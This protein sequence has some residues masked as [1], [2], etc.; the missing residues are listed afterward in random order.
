VSPNSL[1]GDVAYDF[2]IVGAGS[3]GCVLANRLSRDP[4]TQ[5]LLLEAGPPDRKA[6]VKVPAAWTKLLGSDLDWSYVTQPQP[7]L[8]NRRVPWPRGKTLGG[9]SSINAQIYLRGHR[10]D[11]DEWAAEGNDGWGYEAVRPYFERA[12]NRGGA[13]S[14]A[15]RSQGP[16]HIAEVPDPHPLSVAWVDAVI[17]AGI[18]ANDG[19]EMDGVGLVELTQ[20]R[21]VRCSTVDAYLRPALGRTNLTVAV[22]AHATRVLFE[23]RRAVAVEYRRDGRRETAR[24]GGEVILSGGVVNSPQ[25][26][27]L[28]GVGP[29]GHLRTQGIDVV[30]DLPGVGRNLQ[31]HFAVTVAFAAGASGPPP[32]LES[33]ANLLRFVVS[34]RGKLTSSGPEACAFVHTTDDMAAPD[35][36][37]L[38]APPRL[39]PLVPTPRW[40]ATRVR[41]GCR[42]L[43]HARTV[44]PTRPRAAAVTAAVVRPASVGFLEL[45]SADPLAPPVIDPRYLEDSGGRDLRVLV[46]GVKL[47]RRL[48]TFPALR[49]H[50]TEEL[51]PGAHVERDDDIEEFVRE[52]AS[53]LQHPIGTCR[54]GSDAMA[55]VD[56]E[57]RVRGMSGLR[58]V[59]ASIM[60][61]IPR[62]HMN[63]PSIM[64]AEKA[65]DLILGGVTRHRSVALEEGRS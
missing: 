60:P 51:I 59:D 41:D 31:D 52:D 42:H 58:V 32:A 9:S 53:T 54:M 11:F 34:R 4:R 50:V 18:P 30:H 63:A 62:G 6:A 17:E 27:L 56:S 29:A 24:A 46:E 64:I 55:V 35:L 10:T 8:H 65:A 36:E 39:R 3:A 44:R 22:G 2:V 57:L 28:S 47:A 37:L 15:S 48:M 38:F 43:L 16:L 13:G 49:F 12:E 25:L 23:G 45:A 61:V 40:A 26:L 7:A 20:R 19:V 14:G 1:S 21:G 33:I 5:V